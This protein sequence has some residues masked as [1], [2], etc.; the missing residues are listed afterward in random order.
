MGAAMGVAWT[1]I[2]GLLLGPWF[3]SF[4]FPILPSW[5][6]GGIAS[7]LLATNRRPEAKREFWVT[8]CLI[9]VLS[10][11]AVFAGPTIAKWNGEQKVHLIF[12]KWQPG[13]APLRFTDS[14]PDFNLTEQEKSLLRQAGIGGQI[15]V[16]GSFMDGSGDESRVVVVMAHQVA[17][18]IRL[19]QPKRANVIYVN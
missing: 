12:A 4:S 7:V 8:I 18:T 14:T 6:M 13:A 9:I 5:V 3:A 19:P 11:A 17:E 10:S 2:A 15:D 16:T 1:L